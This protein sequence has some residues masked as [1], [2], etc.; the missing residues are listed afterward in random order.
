M[1]TGNWFSIDILKWIN[2]YLLKFV[3]LFTMVN[4]NSY[5]L[6]EQSLFGILK[7]WKGIL[8]PEIVRTVLALA[9]PT[10]KSEDMEK[11]SMKKI[12]WELLL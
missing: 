2:K 8:R 5:N 7:M 9:A 4:I 3:L 1:F 11:I 6:H 10:L 12:L